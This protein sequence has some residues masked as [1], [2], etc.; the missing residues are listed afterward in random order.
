MPCLVSLMEFEGYR[1]ASL[2]WGLHVLKLR[3]AGALN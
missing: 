3:K 1:P 2:G